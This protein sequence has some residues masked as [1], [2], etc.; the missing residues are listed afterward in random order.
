MTITSRRPRHA[1]DNSIGIAAPAEKVFDYVTDVRREPEWNPQLR[2]PEKLTAGPVGAGTRY[3]VRFGRGVGTA[4]IE[5]TGFD[6]PRSWSAV[7]TA[8][9]LTV[10]FRGQVTP[11]PRGC[12]LA[13]HTELQPRGVLRVLS[14]LLRRL[15]RRSWAQ[16][17]RAIKAIIER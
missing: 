12:Q 9:R 14:P 11:D 1:V 15:V 10:R 16:D 8:R 6:R 5:N 13:V 7:S 3:R 2:E 17:L 4:I